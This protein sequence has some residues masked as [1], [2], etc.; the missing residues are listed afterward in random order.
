MELNGRQNNNFVPRRDIQ[1]LR[2]ISVLLVVFYHS[3]FLFSG[4]YLGVDVFFTISGYVITEMLLREASRPGGIQLSQFYYRR[5]KR[6]YPALFTLVIATVLSSL[7]VF[8]PFGQVQTISTTA[9]AALLGAGNIAISRL[10]GSYFDSASELNPLLHVWS[11]GVEE[12][13]YFVYPAVLL[14]IARCS[15]I[16][17][18]KTFRWTVILL[19]AV[20][21]VGAEIASAVEENSK[22]VNFVFGFY[23]P[24]GRVWQ[25]GAGVLIALI[26]TARII[27]KHHFRILIKIIGA[28]LILISGIFTSHDV[29]S[30][31][32]ALVPVFGASLYILA[33][34]IEIFRLKKMSTQINLKRVGDFSYSIYLWHWPIIST[35]SV[36]FGETAEQKIAY[37]ALSVIPA[38]ASYNFIEK[39]IRSKQT[40]STTEWRC[41]CV[42]ALVVLVFFASVSTSLI[43]KQII[44]Q[45]VKDNLGDYSML[46]AAAARGCHF[47]SDN[48]V[49]DIS[50][51][52]WNVGSNGDPVYLVGDSNAEQFSEATIVA[53]EEQG[54]PVYIFTGSS[55][56]LLVDVELVPPAGMSKD[57]WDHCRSY[58]E[59]T[60]EWL[61][62]SESGL[63]LIASLDEYWWNDSI[64]II[65]VDGNEVTDKKEK[66]EIYSAALEKTVQLLH[67]FS[68][69][70]VLVQSIPTY[71]RTGWDPNKCSVLTMA[72]RKCTGKM[73]F[74]EVEN[75]QKLSREALLK[76]GQKLNIEVL[77]L[78]N[79]YCDREYC[80]TRINEKNAYRDASHIS[81]SESLAI[82]DYFA[83]YMN[84]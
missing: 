83:N 24:L 78:R 25:F 26:P 23:G 75:L 31:R 17:F 30:N 29:Y 54:R 9:I 36:V 72:E 49:P 21:F 82:A 47:D 62:S 52:G 45:S 81:V 14:L 66:I 68:K 50:A 39:P 67:R 20:S 15:K 10:T 64:A 33:G 63:I 35:L 12:Q 13:F 11:L 6:L 51:C 8:S 59:R 7:F 16:N 76:I 56:P 2:G 19:S 40:I 32:Y 79:R 22:I 84:N 38:V 57:L 48:A 41:V 43:T 28:S 77:D 46:H 5:F 53:A 55:C 27:A 4:G 42:A 80:S 18:Q 69:K 74:E 73:K 37:A 71:S 3:D 1:R 44:P 61:K 70:I 34:D 60:V 58:V 65:G